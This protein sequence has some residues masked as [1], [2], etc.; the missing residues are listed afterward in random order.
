MNDNL[1]LID[2]YYYVNTPYHSCWG[3][4]NAIGLFLFMSE[5]FSSFSINK[6][7]PIPVCLREISIL[8]HNSL[9]NNLNDCGNY[10][11]KNRDKIGVSSFGVSEL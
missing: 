8:P 11:K 7:T 3:Y 6:D 4:P 1:T 2:R 10:G 5:Y 9:K